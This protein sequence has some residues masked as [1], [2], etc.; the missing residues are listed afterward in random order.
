MA[1]MTL[2]SHGQFLQAYSGE[3]SY[4]HWVAWRAKLHLKANNLGNSKH[5]EH[6]SLMILQRDEAHAKA[7]I[8]FL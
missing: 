6:I 1:A 5:I 4:L 7:K 3:N 2:G 8:N